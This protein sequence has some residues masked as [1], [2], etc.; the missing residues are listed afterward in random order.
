MF[1]KKLKKEDQLCDEHYTNFGIPQLLSFDNNVEIDE[2]KTSTDRIALFGR[3]EGMIVRAK[4]YPRM[5]DKHHL[6][7]TPNTLT[8]SELQ[9]AITY[10][11][12]D[13]VVGAYVGTTKRMMKQR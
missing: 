4:L 9:R 5:T 2:C 1:L 10:L 8:Q 3:I 12:A 7:L 13:E 11:G 6:I